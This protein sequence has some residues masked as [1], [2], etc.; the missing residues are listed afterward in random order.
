MFIFIKQR[1][2]APNIRK[3]N[4]KNTIDISQFNLS[5]NYHWRK[6][7]NLYFRSCPIIASHLHCLTYDQVKLALELMGITMIEE[8]IC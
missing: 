7:D 5:K 3:N 2:T 8:Q 4:D 1:A 6:T